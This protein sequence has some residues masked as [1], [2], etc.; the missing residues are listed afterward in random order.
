MVRPK[1]CRRVHGE[2]NCTVFKPAGIPSAALEQ[3]TLAMDEFEAV[4]LADLEQLYH[5]EAAKKMNVSR[6]TFGRILENARKKIARV[7][8]EGLALRIGGG[9]VERVEVRSFTCGGCGHI[10]QEPFGTGRP[11]ACP[12]CGGSDLFRSDCRNP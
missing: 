2:P 4:R 12:S 10:W 1:T 6:Q 11:A 9:V 5:E 3:V 8:V 7:L